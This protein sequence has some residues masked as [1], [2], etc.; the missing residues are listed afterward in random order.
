MIESGNSIVIFTEFVESAIAIHESLGGELLTGD[1]KD[2]QGIVDRFQSGESKVFVG[3]IK[4]GGVGI[5][6]TAAST[7][8]LVDRPWTPGDTAQ[9]ED[10]IHRLGQTNAC[11]AYW[12]QLGVIDTKIDELIASKQ[13]KVDLL[14]EG[15]EQTRSASTSAREIA[16]ELMAIL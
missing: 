2:R 11:F 16:I 14:L 5:T 10:R 12:L 4:A 6:L 9:A 3:T 7:V 8:L 1:S 13:E 15:K